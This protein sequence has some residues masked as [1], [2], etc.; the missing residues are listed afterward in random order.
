MKIPEAKDRLDEEWTK[1]QKLP[2]WDD[3]RV[4]SKVERMRRET[5]EGKT[6]HFA[7][8]MD[9]RHLKNSELEEEFHKYKGRVTSSGDIVMDDSANYAVCKEQGASALQMTA[10]K[11]LDVI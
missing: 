9:L 1:L 7:T 6:V 8:L 3:S 10:A 11:F 2:A 4:T 5:P